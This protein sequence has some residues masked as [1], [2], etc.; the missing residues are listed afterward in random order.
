MDSDAHSDIDASQNNYAERMNL[1]DKVRNAWF[2]LLKT[3]ENASESIVTDNRSIVVVVERSR[4]QEEGI[5]KSMRKSEG[6][7]G[8]FIIFHV[9]MMHTHQ[10]LSNFTLKWYTV[11][12]TP[13]IPQKLLLLFFLKSYDTK[14]NNLPQWLQ[15]FWRVRQW[16]CWGLGCLYIRGQ[17]F[18]S[19][20]VLTPQ[21]RMWVLLWRRRFHEVT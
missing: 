15:G 7:M 19:E 5:K 13:V 4:R 3:L 8:I 12:C 10:C 11:Y 2:H 16:L 20:P 1:G 21:Y 14:F 9:L 6:I 17:S 18:Q